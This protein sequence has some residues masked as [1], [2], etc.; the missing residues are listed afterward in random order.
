MSGPT[1]IFEWLSFSGLAAII[2]GVFAH[3]KQSG[4][5]S[6]LERRLEAQE[7]ANEAGVK[8]SVENKVTLA[9][10]DERLEQVNQRFDRLEKGVERIEAALAQKP[11]ASRTR[12]PAG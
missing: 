3:G 12:K 8:A 2:G 6:E 5:I 1:D 11:V 9:R 7:R 4:K 10:V